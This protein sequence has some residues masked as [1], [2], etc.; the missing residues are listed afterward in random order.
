MTQESD[1]RGFWICSLGAT[2]GTKVVMSVGGK[3]TAARF[4]ETREDRA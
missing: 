2:G 1:G 4:S 3:K